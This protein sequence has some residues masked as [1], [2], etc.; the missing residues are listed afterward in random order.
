MLR[1]NDIWNTKNFITYALYP[2]SYLYRIIIRIRFISTRPKKVSIPVISVGNLS[3]GGTGKT[4]IVRYIVNFFQEHGVETA[5]I[6]RG[7]KG[8]IKHTIKVD[9]SI[10]KAEDVGDEAIL[11]SIDGN[12]WVSPNRY[13]GAQEAIKDGAEVIILDDAHQNFSLQKDISLI[14]VDGTEMFANEYLLPSGPLREDIKSGLRRA[15]GIIICGENEFL[16]SEII[17]SNKPIFYNKFIPKINLDKFKN[18]NVYAFCGI[19]NPRRFFKTLE[20]NGVKVVKKKIFQD[21]HTYK[22]TEVDNI[23]KASSKLNL[24]AITTEKDITKIKK[25]YHK[26]ISVLRIKVEWRNNEFRKFLINNILNR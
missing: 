10:H 11:H 4:P 15:D 24:V 5:T 20:D 19:G 3:V 18:S 22:D 23:L 26:K 16:H 13:L 17:N 2:I 12:T 7:Y 1:L 21:H 6:L 25:E 8:K 9:Y 14:V